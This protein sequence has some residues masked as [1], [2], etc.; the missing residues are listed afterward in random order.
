MVNWY[1][2]TWTEVVKKLSSDDLSG[3]I[4]EQI[5]IHRE[6]YGSNI[7]NIN[8]PKAF[9]RL[10]LGQ[11][12]HIWVMILILS[13]LLFWFNGDKIYSLIILFLN[14]CNISIASY[15][16]NKEQKN[17]KILENLSETKCVV[18]RSGTIHNISSDDLVVGDIIK[19]KPGDIIPADI[20]LIESERLRVNESV[21]TGEELTVDKY[22]TKIED[23]DISPSE[24]KN[25]VFKSSTVI[26]GYGMGIVVATGSK[27]EVYNIINKFSEDKSKKNE[28]KKKL[29]KMYNFLIIFCTSITIVLSYIM[30]LEYNNISLVLDKISRILLA[31][32]PISLMI[33]IFSILSIFTKLVSKKGI[34]FK[35]ISSIYK[36]CKTSICIV[37]K[38]GIISQPKMIVNKIYTNGKFIPLNE[39]TLKIDREFRS[40]LN[41]IRLTEVGTL[42]ND[43]D[44]KIDKITNVKNDFMEIGLARFALRNNI[45]KNQLEDTYS[46]LFK[47]PYDDDKRIMTTINRIDNNYRANVKGDLESIISRCTHIM[48]NGIEV[49]ITEEDRDKLKTAHIEMSKKSLCVTALAYRSFKYEPSTQENIESNLVFIGI[50]GFLNPLMDDLDDGISM[51]RYLCVSP[52][53]ITEDD[54]LTAY[55]VG[56]KIGILQRMNQVISGVEIDNTKE[57]ELEKIVDRIKVFSRINY[58][59]KVKIAE[60]YKKKGYTI[61]MEGSKVTDLPSLEVSDIGITNENC[62]ILKKFSSVILKNS[63]LKKL[64]VSLIHSKKILKSMINIILYG[65]ISVSSI[66][67]FTAMTQVF[68]TGTVT[69]DELFFIKIV[70]VVLAS[71]AMI[72]DYEVQDYNIV[73]NYSLIKLISNNKIK[74]ILTTLFISGISY[75]LTLAYSNENIATVSSIFIFNFFIT[76]LPLGFNRTL[77]FK[78]KISNILICLN[79]IISTIFIYIYNSNVLLSIFSIKYFK[80]IGVI[81]T[82]WILI[83][84]FYNNEDKSYSL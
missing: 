45:N 1:N 24:M 49:E 34:L 36:F 71:I 68:N 42:C 35:D 9:I 78:N 4:K 65:L 14:I 3:L 54:K 22:S 7:I 33:L 17:I 40:D 13:S 62:G 31:Y 43:S 57:E 19:L 58:K 69:Y 23:K 64:F 38:I 16:D 73:N 25:I 66:F 51:S 28:F 59:H 39:E 63:S 76:T 5:D 47:I 41:V 18:L 30:Y 10:V 53:M 26:S 12:S 50:V 84:I 67:M 15:M 81:S 74:I 48:K 2:L 79:I 21:V 72:L 32:I 27:T 11:I 55:Y 61:A 46:R 60:L 8:K 82:I 44:F 80:I 77:F 56:K 83:L 6:K 75:Y 37:D 52:I 20:R 29:E 70:T